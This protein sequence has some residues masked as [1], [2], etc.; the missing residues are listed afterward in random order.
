MIIPHHIIHISAHKFLRT[1]ISIDHL[2]GYIVK[3]IKVKDGSANDLREILH[4][5]SIGGLLRKTAFVATYQDYVVTKYKTNV[6]VSIVIKYVAST[7]AQLPQTTKGIIKFAKE[8][9][10]KL[11]VINDHGVVYVDFKKANLIPTKDGYIFIDFGASVPTGHIATS[12]T[13]DYASLE[14]L[15]RQPLDSRHDVYALASLITELIITIP[16]NHL[17]K[18]NKIFARAEHLGLYKNL[19]TTVR[20]V[21][22]KNTKFAEL[23]CSALHPN[24][25]RRP[26]IVTF[27]K[28]LSKIPS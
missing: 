27:C 21:L 9:A 12:C 28:A 1:H 3:H 7:N 17:Y 20:Y 19:C 22:G 18:T 14:L 5:M 26:D 10:H 16:P 13:T 4:E 6:V 2:S 15:E 25:K 11:K 8:I 24:D 23:L